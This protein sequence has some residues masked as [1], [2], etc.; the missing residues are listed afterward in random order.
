MSKGPPINAI[1]LQDQV[2]RFRVLFPEWKCVVKH[3]QTA[4]PNKGLVAIGQVQPNSN[5]DSYRT[6]I[7]YKIGK[8]PRVWIES[9]ELVSRCGEKIPHMYSQE[10]VCCFKPGADWDWSMSVAGYI[11]GRVSQWLYFYELWHAT[12]I[13]HGRGIHPLQND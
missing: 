5:G 7:E 11:P 3:C 4:R 8:A 10:R 2:A 9:P 13:W 12:G 1:G 6:R